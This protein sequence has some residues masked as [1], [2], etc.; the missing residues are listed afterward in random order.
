MFWRHHPETVARRIRSL[1]PDVRLIA[2]LRNPVDR[3]Q[4]AMIHHIET[5]RLAPDTDLLTLVRD[6]APRDDP[7]GIISG[8]WYAASL[9]TYV[10]LFG[11]QLLV[12]LHDELREDPRR[13]YGRA[14]HHVGP[15]DDFVPTEIERVRFSFRQRPSGE[16]NR[17][18]LGRSGR[19][20]LQAYF[21]EDLER[22]EEL[23][24]RDLT[25]WKRSG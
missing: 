15:G 4:S 11:D 7:L 20:E 22:L 12:V 8:G 10:D 14:L 24:G 17:Q 25:A 13:L 1:L 18:P 3:A 23:L 19:D 16:P 2:I 9:Q 5:G 21:A 6:V